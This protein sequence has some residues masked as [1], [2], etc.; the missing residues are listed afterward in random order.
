MLSLRCHELATSKNLHRRD[1]HSGVSPIVDILR[2][3]LDLFTAFFQRTHS[4]VVLL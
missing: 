4:L 3:F 2:K 1:V